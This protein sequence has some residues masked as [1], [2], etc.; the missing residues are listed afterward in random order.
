MT[1]S[2]LLLTP[3]SRPPF[4]AALEILHKRAQCQSSCEPNS[5]TEERHLG[6]LKRFGRRRTYRVT[7][8]DR[9]QYFEI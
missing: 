5:S 2:A 8:G 9:C 3:T 7:E 4:S 6:V 1:V